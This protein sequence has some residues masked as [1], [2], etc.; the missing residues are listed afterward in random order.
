MVNLYS[1]IQNL[2]LSIASIHEP[3]ADDHPFFIH[4]VL[5]SNTTLVIREDLN[6]LFN[7]ENDSIAVS[8]RIWQSK[9]ILLTVHE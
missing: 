1:C 8:E 4:S 2:D 9:D 3:N 6:L 7:P 5:C